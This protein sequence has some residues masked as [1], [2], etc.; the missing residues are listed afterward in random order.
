MRRPG[1]KRFPAFRDVFPSANGRIDHKMV[2]NDRRSPLSF[3]NKQTYVWF[4]MM[5]SDC[6]PV[7]PCATGPGPGRD[8]VRLRRRT[9]GT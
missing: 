9:I 6:L 4:E 7:K 3:E 1:S 2:V 8:G 5:I